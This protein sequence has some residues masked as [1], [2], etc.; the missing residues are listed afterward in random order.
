MNIN[1]NTEMVTNYFYDD[2]PM[3]PCIFSPQNFP[4]TERASSINFLSSD[5]SCTSFHNLLN[6][7]KRK[8]AETNQQR[9]NCFPPGKMLRT[10]ADI[11]ED[12]VSIRNDGTDENFSGTD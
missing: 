9:G 3:L 10:K 1:P 8:P 12:V 7:L 6:L 5:K 11:E 4:S 2:C